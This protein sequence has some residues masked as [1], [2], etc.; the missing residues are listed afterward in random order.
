MLCLLAHLVGMPATSSCY[1]LACLHTWM[2]W[3]PHAPV[4]CLLACTP[5]WNVCHILLLC[6]SKAESFLE[7]VADLVLGL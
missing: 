5:G 1:V 6:A 4:M 7:L 3:V 2:E